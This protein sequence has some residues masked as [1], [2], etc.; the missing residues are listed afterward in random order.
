MKK[1]YDTCALLNMQEEAFED[2]CFVICTETIKEMEN[3]KTSSSKDSDIKYKARNMIRLLENNPAKYV[4]RMVTTREETEAKRVMSN[5]TPDLLIVA[6]AKLYSMDEPIVFITDDLCC[7]KIAESIFHLK[8]ARTIDFLSKKEEYIGY[9]TV[10]LSDDEMAYLYSHTNENIYDLLINQYL[11]ICNESGEIVD[12]LKWNG[13]ELFPIHFRNISNDIS[14]KVKPRNPQQELAFD[15]L[16]NQN[17]TVKVLTGGYGSGKDFM[18]VTNALHL[19]KENKFDKIVWV[20]NNIEVKNSKPIGFLPDGLKDKLL[21]FAMPLADHVGG[22][23][24]LDLMIRQGRVEIQHLGFIRG[25]DIKNSIIICSE[26]ENMTKEHIQLL[27]GRVGDGSALW[28]NGDYKQVD[29]LIF[30]TNS[31]LVSAINKLKGNPLFAFVKLEKTERSETAA[32]AD[33]L[34]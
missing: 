33:L 19:I 22:E 16:Q 4:T 11:M 25:R 21:P 14:G 2:D 6:C 1:F 30:E 10:H 26:S 9:K 28:L 5:V 12:K 31:G 3:I 34:D 24:G 8:C 15:M 32:L 29:E 17:A 13:T 23:D 20:R 7:K 18:M 27:I